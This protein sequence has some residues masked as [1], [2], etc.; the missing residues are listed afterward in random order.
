MAAPEHDWF[1]HAWFDTLGKVQNDLHTQ[2][3]LPKNT[4][5]RLWHGDQP[6]RKD[7]LNKIASWL[8]I[9]PYE[10]LLHP[11]DAF[12]IRRLKAA[13]EGA[14]RPVPISQDPPPKA[15]AVAPAQTPKRRRA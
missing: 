6:Y 4:M 8:G 14:V 5:S 1:L 12:Q 10:L 15:D 3:K 9:Q 13:V 11:Q 2:L 7:Y